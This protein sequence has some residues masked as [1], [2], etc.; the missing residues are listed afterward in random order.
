M[1]RSNRSTAPAPSRSRSSRELTA[2]VTASGLS[3]EQVDY[4]V[5]AVEHGAGLAPEALT[6][7]TSLLALYNGLLKIAAES[8]LYKIVTEGTAVKLEPEEDPAA[9]PTGARIRKALAGL[10][11]AEEAG[12]AMAILEGTTTLTATEQEEFIKEKLGPYLDASAAIGKLVGGGALEKGGPRFEYVLGEVLAYEVK[13]LSTAFIVQS[14]ASAL[15]AGTSGGDDPV[16]RVVPRGH[17]PRS[18]R[19]LGFPGPAR[20]EARQRDRADLRERPGIRR[21]TS[22]PTPR[23]PRRRC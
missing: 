19:D 17:D 2:T 6:V 14:L 15:G 20:R 11:S 9:D 18:V 23:S 12:A 7:G 4:L 10:L 3:V 13:T 5:R 16:D 22:A 1:N 21:A 8:G